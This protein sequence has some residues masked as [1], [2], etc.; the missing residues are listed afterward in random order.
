MGQVNGNVDPAHE[1]ARQVSWDEASQTFTV[2]SPMEDRGEETD[3]EIEGRVVLTK[4][5]KG[6]A[7]GL[8]VTTRVESD[9]RDE[10]SELWHTLP[11]YEGIV[12]EDKNGLPNRFTVEYWDGNGWS[13]LGPTA[14]RSTKV[15][16]GHDWG[17]GYVYTYATLDGEQSACA[18]CRH[19]TS[20]DDHRVHLLQVD[21]HGNPGT[22]KVLPAVSEVTYQLRTS[23]ADLGPVAPRAQ[24]VSVT[25]QVDTPVGFRLAASDAN[26]DALTY[27]LRSS[28]ARGSLTGTAPNLTYMP[29]PGY[30]GTD[31]FTF[32]ANDGTANSNVATV[33]ITVNAAPDGDPVP[34]DDPGPDPEEAKMITHWTFD[35]TGATVSD[36]SG[37]GVNGT[38]VG[39]TRVNEGWSGSALS[40]D[41]ID[42]YVDAGR[43][44]MPSGNGATIA[45]WF[46]ADDFDVHDARFIS[47]ATGVQER[48]HYWM[49]STI[50]RTALRFRLKAGGTTT[51]LLTSTNVIRPGQWYHVATTYD[52]SQMRIF[53]NGAE[54]T[55]MNKS[56]AIDVNGSVPVAVGNQPD[57]TGD[58][59]F[60]GRLDDL[61]VYNY[62][63][64]ATAIAEIIDQPAPRTLAP[65]EFSPNGGSFSGPIQVV[66]TAD[67]EDAEIRYTLDG[68]E[69]TESSSLYSGPFTVE[70]TAEVQARTF[71]EGATPSTVSKAFFTIDAGDED[72][73]DPLF[74]YWPLDEVSGNIATDAVGSHDGTLTNGPSWR[75]SD[76]QYGGALDFDGHDDRVDLGAF[77]TPAGSE[78]TIAFWFNAD[79]FDVHDARFISKATG[80]Q[81]REHYWM[82]STINKTA[83][84][85]RL[86]AGNRTT[87]LKSPRNVIEPNRW[88][89]VTATYDGARMRLYLDGEELVSTRKSGSIFENDSVP[90]ALGN[91]PGGAGS[92]A[93]DGQLDDVRIYG[94]ALDASQVA[95]LSGAEFSAASMLGD[96][97]GNGTV[98]ALDAALVLQYMAGLVQFDEPSISASEVSGNELVSSLDASYILRYTAGT[99]ECLPA[100]EGCGGVQA[101]KHSSLSQPVRLGWGEP[102]TG[103][104]SQERVLPLTILEGHDALQAFDMTLHFDPDQ[105]MVTGVNPLVAGGWQLAYSINEEAGI[106]KLS[107]AGASPATADALVS[108]SLDVKNAADYTITAT[109]SVNEGDTQT[110]EPVQAAIPDG[111]GLAQNYPNPFNPTTTIRY[112]VSDVAQVQLEVFD[113]TGRRV[114][115][116]VNQVKEA[117][118][119]E[120]VFDAARLPSGMYFYRLKAGGFIQTHSMMLLK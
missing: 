60:D 72:I 66:L 34:D 9:Q 62:A 2:V 82:V 79:N 84:R 59:P 98:S 95:V 81:E 4:Q 43:F 89:H 12:L 28:P 55:K 63:L 92:R 18:C 44:D 53:L 94:T 71:L 45:F 93:F 11:V 38:L 37:N 30:V 6:L 86:K 50:N 90:V 16:I 104:S 22:V 54:I 88:Y 65:P 117:G 115:T 21:L 10:V 99:I 35:G 13:A 83:L 101:A 120:T 23:E 111:F 67:V 3:N 19:T 80:I 109:A 69:P 64:D 103:A 102:E 74:A 87:T 76:G 68:T 15:R 5:F 96:A 91:Q 24:D 47:K 27:T 31:S 32:V 42:D 29:N 70:T 8:E 51:T 75:S 77:D 26:G 110:I 56:G 119:Y 108:V 20:L 114:A 36:E 78:L 52:G 17:Q 41:G 46:N 106:V 73:E 118:E 116:L 39:P 112:Q 1:A 25:T 49:V 14:V 7:D 97:S 58:R 105:V 100:E 85:F 107:M 113:V 61:R 40:F 33:S 57:G 48:D